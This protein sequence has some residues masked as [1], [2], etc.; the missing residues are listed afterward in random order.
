[1]GTWGSP[2][3]LNDNIYNYG[4]LMENWQTKDP[5]AY[6]RALGNLGELTPK[7]GVTATLPEMHIDDYNRFLEDYQKQ[8]KVTPELTAQKEAKDVQFGAGRVQE[9]LAR[10]R[11]GFGSTILGSLGDDEER[12]RGSILG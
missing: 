5:G 6:E 12:R 3:N 8:I 10:Q 2:S 9:L 11:S 7:N 4:A 1:M